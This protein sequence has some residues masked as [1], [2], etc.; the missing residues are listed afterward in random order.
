MSEN[1]NEC[2][3]GDKTYKKDQLTERQLAMQTLADDL[4][5]RS[6]RDQDAAKLLLSV[7]KQQLETDCPDRLPDEPDD[8]IVFQTIVTGN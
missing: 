6:K 3:F 4:L 5:E 2:R 1:N 7:L 8:D